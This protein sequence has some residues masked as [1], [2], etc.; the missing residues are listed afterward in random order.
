[1]S[2][3]RPTKFQILMFKVKRLFFLLLLVW[4]AIRCDV[5]RD[6]TTDRAKP[7]AT[8]EPNN[9]YGPVPPSASSAEMRLRKNIVDFAQTKIGTTYKH[10]GKTPETG[11]DCSGFT[12]YVMNKH[13]IKIS[14][15]S[16]D[17][18][19]QGRAIDVTAVKPG[20]LIFFRR[21]PSEPIFH[22]S[23][24]VSND[25]K[26]V[27]VVHSTTSRG[28]IVDNITASKYWK[29]YIDSAKDVVA[30]R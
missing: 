22:V 4:L 7:P 15:S 16:R 9:N 21:G 20:D 23:L 19:L 17:Q 2:K 5:L 13:G 28:V 14:P 27:R 30:K 18:A 1:M 3:Q 10:A 8:T 12:S 25:G 26:D 11:F 24:V 29:P 6:L